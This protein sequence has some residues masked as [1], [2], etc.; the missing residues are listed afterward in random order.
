MSNE[1]ALARSCKVNQL[2]IATALGQWR[3]RLTASKR[4]PRCVVRKWINA[5]LRCHRAT[6]SAACPLRRSDRRRPV[7]CRGTSDIRH[8]YGTI[9]GSR[10][11]MSFESNIAVG[12]PS[13][14]LAFLRPSTHIVLMFDAV[15][16]SALCQVRR[17]AAPLARRVQRAGGVSNAS[18]HLP[19]P[20]CSCLFLQAGSR[21]AA[22]ANSL[23]RGK[24]VTL[25][26][27]S[28]K[29]ERKP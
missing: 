8:A 1:R 6:F 22:W 2:P 25:P 11:L 10:R 19:R 9:S 17:R 26:V 29:L 20:D 16:R 27:Q 28:R 13:P 15:P 23:S 3:L 4:K 12:G 18:G 24:L 21:R 5:N 7:Q 14:K